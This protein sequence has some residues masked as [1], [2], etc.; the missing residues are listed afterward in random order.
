M[1]FDEC[2]FFNNTSACG[3]TD[4]YIDKNVEYKNLIDLSLSLLHLITTLMITTFS[5]PMYP[6]TF[7]LLNDIANF[8]NNIIL[9]SVCTWQ[10]VILFS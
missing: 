8:T 7:T 9:A 1:A 3:H 4:V 6:L 5:K 2:T 10:N